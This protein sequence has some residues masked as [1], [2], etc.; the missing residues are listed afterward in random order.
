[1]AGSTVSGLA[2]AY[3]L[4]IH[5]Y[6]NRFMEYPYEA[7]LARQEGIARLRFT[8]DR[9][10]R[11]LSYELERGTNFPLL[12]RQA[13]HMLEKANP[14]PPIPEDLQRSRMEVVLPVAF[15]LR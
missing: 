3:L 15:S 9:S 14:L 8:I 2:Q 4:R 5:A 1:M 12:D 13:L 6:L 10:G 7:R 11:I